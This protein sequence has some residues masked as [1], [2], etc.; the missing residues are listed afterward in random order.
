[1][2]ERSGKDI[3]IGL[4]GVGRHGRRYLDH[5][6][7]EVPGAFLAAISRQRAEERP[8]GLPLHIPVYGDYRK[9]I[10]DPRVQAVVIV[11]PP[12][13]CRDICLTS[14]Q[15][16]KPLLIEKP[17]AG[18]GEEARAM[19]AAAERAGVML[20]T[21]QTM[22]FDP[23]ILSAKEHLPSLGVLR[24]A[25]LTSHIEWNASLVT[26]TAT[27]LGAMLEL[28]IHLLDLVRFLTGEEVVEA[29]CRMDRP[30][31]GG[32]ETAARAR[33]RTAGGTRCELDIARVEAGRIG[34]MNWTGGEGSMTVDWVQ[35]KI[36]TQLTR[37][38]PR[39]WTVE[40]RPTIV[41]VLRS[42]IH[43]IATGAPPPVTGV[44]GCRAVEL[45]DACYASDKRS[46]VP[47]PIV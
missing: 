47:V 14:V 7:S 29:A 4:I 41:A 1:M 24:E 26:R 46:G 19:V 21:A 37:D 38:A 34:T 45:A 12:S 22:R 35:R 44:D 20:M 27:P 6:L 5:L 36:V 25:R 3:G 18:T 40:A 33:L 43:A 30:G 16:G 2:P 8:E 39:E 31:K 11:T 10:A 23:T 42:F 13:L 9:L 15:A 17:L 28:G 32:S